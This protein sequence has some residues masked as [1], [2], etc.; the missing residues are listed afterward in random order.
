MASEADTLNRI[1]RRVRK[2]KATSREKRILA[3]AYG[4]YGVPAPRDIAKELKWI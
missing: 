2:K 4:A 1:E 3:E